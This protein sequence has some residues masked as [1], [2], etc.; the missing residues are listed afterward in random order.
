M[1]SDLIAR[2]ALTELL[3]W[4]ADPDRKPLVVR[5][6]RQV[7]KSCLVRMFSRNY[8]RY[9]ELNLERPTHAE[10]FRRGLSFP[11]LVQ[12]IQLEC[13]V[14]PGPDPM[15]LFLDE[16]QEAP[17]AVAALRY[18]REDR[19]DLHVIA[20]GSLLETALEAAAISFPVGRVQFLYLRPF[21]FAEF[22]EA[23]GESA[24]I[25]ALNA[26]PA[27][28]HAHSR[29][30]TLFH[31]YALI[32]GMPEAVLKYRHT[33]GDL[34]EVNRVYADLFA[35]FGDDIPKYGRNETL[36]RILLHALDSAPY[37]AGSRVTFQGFGGSHY[38]SREVGEALRE[39][40]RAMLLELVYPTTQTQE[41]HMPDRRKSPRLHF[42]D[43]GLVNHRAG[44]QRQLIGIRDLADVYRGRLIEQVVG[45]EIKAMD[46]RSDTPLVFWVR[47]KAQSH[48]EVDFL[49]RTAAGVIPVEAKSGAAGK[50]RSLHEYMGRGGGR[51]AVRLYAG[52]YG[53]QEIAAPNAAYR[54]INIPYYAAGRISRYLEV[55]L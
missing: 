55:S 19:P 29:L 1:T 33:H 52:A 49:L 11:D 12:A 43:V 50:L 9:A 10:L 23:L 35:A 42:L 27:P 15:L 39:M 37:E 51:V 46:V 34:M 17:E 47:D 31:A 53:I 30:L 4:K 8:R 26:V 3:R 7:G 22:L 2:R 44:L 48:A 24:A 40:E 13:A 38:R 54:L 16:I 6:A 32:G 21:D 45:Q 36:R 28:P 20:A 14:P 5:G 18:F 25:E 41:P